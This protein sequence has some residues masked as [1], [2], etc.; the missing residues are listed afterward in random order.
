MI[1]T[2]ATPILSSPEILKKLDG[3]KTLICDVDY[4]VSDFGAGNVSGNRRIREALGDNVA[5][6]M[7][8]MFDL[9]L[10]GHRNLELL[11][12]SEQ[13]EYKI[14][15]SKV[16]SY[17]PKY[18]C[19]EMY[20][21]IATKKF[22]MDMS[23]TEIMNAADVYWRGVSE[24]LQYYPDAVIF[25]NKAKELSIPLIWMT[26]SDSRTKVSKNYSDEW[27]IIYDP[28]YSK[29]KKMKR[30]AGLLHDFP[31]LIEIGDPIDKPEPEFYDTVFAHTK[32]ISY[33]D[34]LV[35]GDSEVNDLE[36]ARK[37]GCQTVLIKR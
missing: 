32:G 2:I 22:N 33:K 3:I 8:I 14:L 6:E 12:E 17:T 28:D 37:R 16:E 7:D 4:T 29:N 26:G 27:L 36:N 23:P 10:R 20:L 11:S 19:R 31:G 18:W 25:L 9:I 34:I 13:R 1:E 35:V 24:T 5:N 15:M 21:I 30:I